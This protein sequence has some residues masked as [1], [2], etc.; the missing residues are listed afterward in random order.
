ME[1]VR[2]SVQR[3]P[4]AY[5]EEVGSEDL[6]QSELEAQ[7]AQCDAVIKTGQELLAD[8]Q[9]HPVGQRSQERISAMKD[10][11]SLVQGARQ[12]LQD[13]LDKLLAFNARSPQIFE[14]LSALE[15]ALETG[16]SQ[17]KG[18]WQ[19]DS[20]TFVIPSD[21]SWARTID[22][23]Q[24]AKVYQVSRPD[25]MSEQDYQVYLS[26]LHDQVKGF[27][28]DGWTKKAI[29][30]GYLSAV[31]V[32]YDSRQ[33]IPLL[34]QLAAFYEEA[35]T[36]GSGIFQKMWG[37][38]LKK[39]GE[40]SD[41]AQALLQIAMSYSGMPEGDL[42][43]SAEQT[44]GILAHLS[45][46]LAP[47]ARFWD[48]FSKAVQVAYPGDALSSAGGNET[49]KRQV[50]QF[51]YVI[52][53]QQAQWVRDNYRKGEMTDE[54]ALAAYL[55]D[56]DAK[57]NIF[58]KLG[59][60][61]FDYDLT[62]SSRLHNKTAVNPD[63]DEVEYPGGIYSSN[64]K[65]VMKF[66]TEFIIG[67]DGQF[68]NEID[69]EKDYQFNERGV[70]NGASF[71]YADSNDELHNQLDV[72]TVSLWDP[73]YRVNTIHIGEDNESY[74]YESPT[75]PQYRDNTSGQFSYGN[76]SSFDNVQKEIENFKELIREYGD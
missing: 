34:Q 70:V 58:E 27:E 10:S 18:A 36:F 67:S 63:T 26:T 72:K 35:R 23:L 38:D 22:D 42:D 7:I 32:G 49:L 45:K 21:L 40:K 61:D 62:E 60:N 53:A 20:Q 25:G 64:F 51:R 3:L 55:A 74:Q 15:K 41:R 8:M 69:P 52:S 47:D 76:I 56:K 46:D 6:R 11:L 54:E 5:Q 68:L 14:G 37:I 71:N 50:H 29:R 9:A 31:A 19:A 16:R 43:G 28:A 2:E 13:K 44:Q 33:D 30:E 24:F 75:R 4:E 12:E 1:A 17:A 65:L 48:S 59:L 66:H 57:N 73:E 39:A